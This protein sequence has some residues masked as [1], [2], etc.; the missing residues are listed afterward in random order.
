MD[1]IVLAARSGN[2]EKIVF[3]F[4]GY[5]A[6]KDDLLP[7]GE[8]ISDVLPEA[9]I[10]LPNGIEKCGEGR[11]QWF[12]LEGDDVRLWKLAFEKNCTRI[13]SYIDSVINEKSL[14]NKN[15]IFSGFSQ[16]AMLSLSL[17]LKYNAAATIAFSGLLLD[18]EVCADNCDTKILLTHGEKDNVIPITALKLTE[19]ALKK[20][21]I[22]VEIAISPDLAHGIDS[23]LLNQAIDFLKR[24]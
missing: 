13:T 20:Y 5:G 17:G 3:L 4:H 24:L 18:P 15:V 8:R 16:G 7:I 6:D 1:E 14:T 21:G 10:R 12:G 22:S 19:E 11:R 2:V 23:Y 9:E